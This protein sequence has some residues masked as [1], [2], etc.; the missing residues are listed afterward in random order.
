[1]WVP[2]LLV[3]AYTPME[4]D[5]GSVHGGCDLGNFLPNTLRDRPIS[6]KP[7]MREGACPPSSPETL[8][9][10]LEPSSR[11]VPELA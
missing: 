6:P 5:H 11:M 7:L 8:Q 1:M 9:E 4:E 10:I 2:G 3:K